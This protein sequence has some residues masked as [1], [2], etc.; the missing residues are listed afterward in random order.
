PGGFPAELE[1][2]AVLLARTVR[3]V[4]QTVGE[5]S[6]RNEYPGI[7]DGL[8]RQ[9]GIT[10]YRRMPEARLRE[11]LEWLERWYGDAI[12]EPEPPPDI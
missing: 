12:G 8:Y 4:A 7:F 9:W 10:S 1:A 3:R 5:R 2:N 11:A 6:R